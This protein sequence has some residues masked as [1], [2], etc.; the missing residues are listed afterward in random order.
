MSGSSTGGCSSC[1]VEAMGITP[2]LESL[3]RFYNCAKT[4]RVP[5]SNKL[6]ALRRRITQSSLEHLV[7][8][9][10]ERVGGTDRF[11][12]SFKLLVG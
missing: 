2:A 11:V 12:P 6:S 7:L 4:M 1:C 3:C 5:R 8:T 9:T 10:P